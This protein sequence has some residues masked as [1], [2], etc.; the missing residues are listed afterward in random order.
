MNGSH[1]PEDSSHWPGVVLIF[2]GLFLTGFGTS[3]FYSLSM[4]YLD[5]NMTRKASPIYIALSFVVRMIGAFMGMLLSSGF[6]RLGLSLRGI[7]QWIKH[8]PVATADRAQA[9]IRPKIFFT[10][11]KNTESSCPLGYPLCMHSR[12]QWL[13]VTLETGDSYEVGKKE[14]LE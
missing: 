9:R 7:A 4:A 6:L 1:R 3:V 14:E 12:S 8:S 2:L 13:R 5:D 11:E 10:Y